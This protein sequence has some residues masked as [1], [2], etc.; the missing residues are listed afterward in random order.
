[1]LYNNH[2]GTTYDESILDEIEGQPEDR[3]LGI[4]LTQKEIRKAQGKMTY[5]KSPSPNGIPA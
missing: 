5:E 3:E 2:E 1:M 4:A